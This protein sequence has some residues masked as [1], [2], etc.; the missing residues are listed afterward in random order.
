MSRCITIVLSCVLPLAGAAAAQAQTKVLPG[1][2]TTISAVVETIEQSSRTLTLRDAQGDLHTIRVPREVKRFPEIKVGDTVTA[3]YYDNITLRVKQPG[4]KDV[5]TL[6]AGVTPGGG[7][8]PA[9]TAS[10]QQTITATIDTI[11][12]NVPSISFK[13]PRGW[14]YSTKVQDK[15]ALSQVKVG[16]KVDITWTEALLVSVAAPKKGS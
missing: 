10:A 3:T 8:R 9:G 13:G 15:K 2:H 11:D 16:D 1:E 5:D 12:M 4:E 6:T 14:S 7:R